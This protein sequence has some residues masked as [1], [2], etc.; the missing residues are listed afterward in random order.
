[1]PYISEYDVSKLPKGLPYSPKRGDIVF[2]PRGGGIQSGIVRTTEGTKVT[3]LLLHE[4]GDIVAKASDLIRRH[5]YQERRE[6]LK[7]PAK[8]KKRQDEDE[9]EDDEDVE[10][11]EEDDEEE[12]EEEE[13]EK[14]KKGKKGKKSKGKKKKSKGD[15]EVTHRKKDLS[16]NPAREGTKR[17]ALIEALAK[18][19]ENGKSADKILEKAQEIYKKA[20]GGKLTK[21]DAE[22]FERIGRAGISDLIKIL[23]DMGY[24]GSFNNEGKYGL[25]YKK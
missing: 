9:D 10:E 24:K 5:R 25:K 14:P 8:K 20:N 13:D 15:D 16:E 6:D 11:E 2:I 23:K 18:F 17:W 21:D 7:M 1:M 12:E 19:P 3:V 22:K 4:K